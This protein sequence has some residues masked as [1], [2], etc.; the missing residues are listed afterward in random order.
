MSWTICMS[1]KIINHYGPEVE[2]CANGITEHNWEDILKCIAYVLNI[3]DPDEWILEQLPLF[4]EWALE[5][6]L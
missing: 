6:E 4:S 2:E 1:K 5:C 3:A